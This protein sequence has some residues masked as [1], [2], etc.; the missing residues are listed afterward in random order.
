MDH[1][2]NAIAASVQPDNGPPAPAARGVT[3]SYIQEVLRRES[4]SL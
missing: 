4:A 1:P 2:S 3:L